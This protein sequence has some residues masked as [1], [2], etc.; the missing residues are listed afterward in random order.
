MR[1]A[2]FY[3]FSVGQ[4]K[5]SHMRAFAMTD[6]QPNVTPSILIYILYMYAYIN[7]CMCVIYELYEHFVQTKLKDSFL[8]TE[9]FEV[10][11]D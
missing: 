2:Y 6:D 5:K 8:K 3:D 10:F 7:M 1:R 9:Q 4:Q 11:R